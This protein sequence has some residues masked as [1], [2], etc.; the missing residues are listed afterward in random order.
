MVVT[1]GGLGPGEGSSLGSRVRTLD[2][3]MKEF[4]SSEIT[5]NILE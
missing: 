5:R 3:Q 1:Q 2:D 4:I